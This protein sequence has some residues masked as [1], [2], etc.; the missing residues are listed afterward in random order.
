METGRKR[1]IITGACAGF[2]LSGIFALVVIF[3]G[4]ASDVIQDIGMF[5]GSTPT[6]LA[7]MVNSSDI[8]VTSIFLIY[9][10]LTGG[11][12]GF[13]WTMKKPVKYI[14]MTSLVIILAVIHYMTMVQLTRD[15]EEAIQAF[16]NIW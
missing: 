6:Y 12:F 10:A 16:A 8:F 7:A 13:L 3:L 9:W 14:A 2:V 1:S 15:I 4:D 5:F 11:M